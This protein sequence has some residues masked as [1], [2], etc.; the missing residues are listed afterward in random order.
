ME[1]RI[2]IIVR[3]KNFPELYENLI[4]QRREHKS[5]LEL[6]D[7]LVKE[8]ERLRK[9]NVKQNDWT[10][11]RLALRATEKNSHLL[12]EMFNNLLVSRPIPTVSTQEQK[13]PNLTSFERNWKHYIEGLQQE[14]WS[15]HKKPKTLQDFSQPNHLVMPAFD[16]GEDEE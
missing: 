6:L 12:I 13:S 16:F 8:N 3:R 10:G 9:E 7:S 5:Y 2:N 15:H 11:M 14:R 1:E 4:E